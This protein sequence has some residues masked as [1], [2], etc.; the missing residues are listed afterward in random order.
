MIYKPKPHY[1]FLVEF[2]LNAKP[3]SFSQYLLT[4]DKTLEKTN[5]IYYQNREGSNKGTLAPPELW[6]LKKGA[7]LAL[8]HHKILE[9]RPPGQIKT[10]HLSKDTKILDFFEGY[11]QEKVLL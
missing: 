1:I 4:L 2:D 10:I 6:V 7:F 9:G 3:K 8:E 5:N 11:L